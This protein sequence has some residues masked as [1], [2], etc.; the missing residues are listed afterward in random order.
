MRSEPNTCGKFDTRDGSRHTCQFQHVW[1]VVACVTNTTRMTNP[2]HITSPTCVAALARLAVMAC[3]TNLTHVTVTTRVTN[4]TCS[5][6]VTAAARVTNT[7]RKMA[8]AHVA[9]MTT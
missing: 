2:A 9:D 8:M 3:V 6:L 1:G 5:A 7:T 4:T